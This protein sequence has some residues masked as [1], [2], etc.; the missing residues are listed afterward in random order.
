MNK[1][2]F[3]RQSEMRLELL[4]NGETEL[5]W[6]IFTKGVKGPIAK[7]IVDTKQTKILANHEPSAHIV[8]VFVRKEY[9]GRKLGEHLVYLAQQALRDNGFVWVTLE[10]EENVEHHGRLVSLYERCGFHIFPVLPTFQLIYNGD[11]CFRKIP[12]RCNLTE[13]HFD[14]E[15]EEAPS[16]LTSS[17]SSSLAT[18]TAPSL[19]ETA[20][21]YGSLHFVEELKREALNILR[22][23]P[24][25]LDIPTALSWID[26]HIPGTM[27]HACR[28]ASRVRMLGHPDW[29]ELAG[30]LLHLGRIQEKW[31]AWHA[32]YMIRV[33]ETHDVNQVDVRPGDGKE[34]DDGAFPDKPK[35]GPLPS[36]LKSPKSITFIDPERFSSQGV[37]ES[38]LSWGPFEYAYL[39]I[40]VDNR[41]TA[42]HE[43]AQVLRYSQCESWLTTSDYSYIESWEDSD[44]K[45]LTTSFVAAVREANLIPPLSS[46]ELEEARL[47]LFE[48][49]DKY[50]SDVRLM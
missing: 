12:M 6:C 16:T 3:A 8:N 13:M 10:A 34:N 45:Q 22:S 21:R 30:F 44:V 41:S 38:M 40:N 42:P 5:R 4:D 46:V 39:S 33:A 14:T 2:H 23:C 49:V 31:V 26:D 32:P 36:D 43:M 18:S 48:L 11:E 7:I 50:V 1:F 27:E 9:R 19:S 47:R 35:C 28:V 20:D 24:A 37:D 25:N 17:S 15:N 29:M